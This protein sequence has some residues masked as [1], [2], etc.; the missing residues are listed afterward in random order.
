MTTITE[1]Y[2]LPE[3]RVIPVAEVKRMLSRLVPSLPA[4]PVIT[5]VEL[6]VLE[7]LVHEPSQAVI[8]HRLFLST[9]TVK[10]HL[11]SIYRKLGAHTRDQAIRTARDRGLIKED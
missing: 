9:N 5:E 3:D 7:Q 6:R 4:A 11:R 10:T 8:A 2:T 1:L